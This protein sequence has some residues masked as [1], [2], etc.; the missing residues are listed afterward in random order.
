MRLF[1]GLLGLWFCE[2]LFSFLFSF[3]L[4]FWKVDIQAHPT[5]RRNTTSTFFPP[6]HASLRSRSSGA[7]SPTRGGSATGMGGGR[8]V[9]HGCTVSGSDL[10]DIHS[11]QVLL[12]L[13][14]ALPDAGCALVIFLDG[15]LS[16]FHEEK[17][18]VSL[19]RPTFLRATLVA[20]LENMVPGFGTVVTATANSYFAGSRL[21]YVDGSLTFPGE[22]GH[23]LDFEETATKARAR[24]P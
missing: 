3:F 22:R 7:R 5:H 8:G 21:A 10:T 16:V 23:G 1:L 2:T 6:P 18:N 9:S 14:P 17:S 13:L 4:S 20:R 24:N 19:G 12:L 11:D 15:L